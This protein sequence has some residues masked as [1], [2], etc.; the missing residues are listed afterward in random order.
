MRCCSRPLRLLLLG[1]LTLQL[2]LPVGADS[3]TVGELFD[4]I[5]SEIRQ[6]AASKAA[7]AEFQEFR[8]THKFQRLDY[9]T[10]LKVKVAYEC[11]RDSGLWHLVYEITDQEPNSKAIW[12]QWRRAGPRFRGPTAKAECDEV[13]ALFAVLASRLGVS[14]IG[15][16]WPTSNHT[17]AV[18]TVEEKRIVVPTTP[19]FLDRYDGFDAQGFDPWSQRTIYE[20]GAKDVSDSVELPA[21][22]AKF[23]L[24]QI[25]DYGG[26]SQKLLHEL[27]YLREALWY[28]RSVEA[29]FATLTARFQSPAD[30]RALKAFSRQFGLKRKSPRG[31]ATGTRGIK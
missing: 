4:Q 11:S 1:V 2:T 15:L 30:R 6:L 26:A 22:L 18:W 13:S 27:R 17:V 29:Q 28:G 31:R 14:G 10:Y 20:Y 12:S 24:S 8:R 25:R 3:V 23:F 5:R 7:H 21:G 9:W 19:I 16:F